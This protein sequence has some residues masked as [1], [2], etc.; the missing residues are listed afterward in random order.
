MSAQATF[1]ARASV[2][3]TWREEIRVWWSEVDRV[4]LVLILLLM[5]TGATAVLAASPA[6]ADRLSTANETLDPFHFLMLHLRWL[7]LGFMGM[8]TVSFFSR[9]RARQ[10]GILVALGM[11]VLLMLVP[12]IGFERKGA[13]RWLDLGFS[14]Q[15][16]EFLKPGFAIAIAWILSWRLRDPH[17]PVFWLVGGI[18]LAIA[19]WAILEM[20]RGH[21]RGGPVGHDCFLFRL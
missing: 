16:S 3:R 18:T 5:A 8:I 1:K 21:G 20:D 19:C 4:L 12:L 13:T 2:Q 17:L 9:D 7:A 10:L 6:S 14:L 11:F 15:P